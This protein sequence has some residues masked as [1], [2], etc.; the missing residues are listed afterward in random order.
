MPSVLKWIAKNITV[1]GIIVAAPCILRG[2]SVY[3]TTA[4]GRAI[5]YDNASAAAGKVVADIGAATQYDTAI[6]PPLEVRCE[7]G[8]YVNLTTASVTVYYELEF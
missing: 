2:V 8:L 5:V 6:T 7:K 1:D 3:S 4:A